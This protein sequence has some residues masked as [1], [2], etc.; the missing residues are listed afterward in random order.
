MCE[1]YF[2][3]VTNNN[4]KKYNNSKGQKT[5]KSKTA[6]KVAIKLINPA[7]VIFYQK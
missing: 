3:K 4:R 1:I 5:G 7:N 6:K 2:F